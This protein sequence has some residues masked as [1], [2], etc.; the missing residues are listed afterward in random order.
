MLGNAETQAGGE[1]LASD[2]LAGRQG[3]FHRVLPNGIAFC[4]LEASGD[5][6]HDRSRNLPAWKMFY[7]CCP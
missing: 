3:R 5:D 4:R 6:F 1:K 2:D 7:A